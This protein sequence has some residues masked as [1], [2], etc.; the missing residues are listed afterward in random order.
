MPKKGKKNVKGANAPVYVF[1]NESGQ[2]WCKTD[3]ELFTFSSE[4]QAEDHAEE[5]SQMLELD[6]GDL[7]LVRIV[8]RF[9]VCPTVEVTRIL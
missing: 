9:Q 2:A 4:S 7:L 1:M 6:G 8:G 5:A 3:Q